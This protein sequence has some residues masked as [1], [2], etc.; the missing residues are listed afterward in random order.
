MGHKT[1]GI[2]LGTNSL[3]IA[4]R[5]TDLGKDILDQL[6]FYTSIIFKSGVGKS[7]KGEY[8]YAS[9][10]TLYRSRRRLYQSRKYRIWATLRLLIKHGCCPLTIEELEQ[11]SKYDKAKGQKRQYPIDATQFEQWV[12]LDF[13]NDGIPEYSSPYQLRAE[14]IERRLDWEDE[15]DR[16]KFGRAMYH[17]AQ[18]RGFKSSK[19]ETLKDAKDDEDSST[20]DVSNAMKKSEEKKSKGLKEYMDAHGLKTVGSAF[21]KLEQEGIRIRN[22]EYQAVQSQYLNEVKEICQYQH[23][24]QI[25]EELFNGLI[26]TKKGEGTIFYRRPLRSQKGNIGSCT[27]ERGRRRCPVSHPDYEEFRALSFINNIKFKLDENDTWQSLS[28]DKRAKLLNKVFIRANATFKFEDIT[29]WLSTEYPGH[30]FS[31]KKR[32]INYNDYTTV[33]GCPIIYRLTKILGDDWR[34]QIISTDKT[35]KVHVKSKK[36]HDIISEHS[37]SYNYEDIWHLCF[38]SDDYETLAEFAEVRMGFCA[39]KIGQIKRLWSIMQDGY[40]SLSLKAI[41][42]ILPLLREGMIYSEAVSLAKVSDIIGSEKWNLKRTDIIEGV[43]EESCKNEYVRTIYHIANTLISDYKSRTI[44]EKQGYRNTSY[45]LD[46]QDKERIRKCI[47]DT[48]SAKRWMQKSKE[49]QDSIYN[50]IETLFQDFFASTR[51]DYYVIP[52]QTERL[53]EYFVSIFPEI[54]EEKWDNLYHHSQISLFQKQQPSIM[55]DGDRLLHIFQ[56]GSPNIGSIKNPVAMRALHVVRRTINELLAKGMIDETTRIVVE[57][58]RD[59]NDANWRKAIERYQKEREKE[60][61]IITDI[62]KEFR[63]N[64][65]ESDIEKGR[66]LFEQIE[67]GNTKDEKAAKYAKATQAEKAK[68]EKFALDLEKYNLWKEQKF[69]CLYTGTYISIKNLFDENMVDIEHT[70]PRSI[71]FDDSLANK[72]ICNAHYNRTIKINRIPSEL[73]EYE[74]ILNRIKPWMEKVEHIKSQ[75]ENWKKNARTATTIERKNECIQQKHQWEMELNYW[76]AKV[77]SFKIQK[78]ELDQGFRNR[79]LVDTRIIT[80]YAFHYLKSVF[81]RVDVQKGS[82]TSTFRKILG[83]QSVDEKKDREKHS[84]H[85]IDAAVLTMIPTSVQRDRMIELFY[86]RQEADELEKD[87]IQQKLLK[88]IS[89]CRLGTINGMVSTIE[90]N[91]LINHIT[92]DQTL[93]PAKKL[94]RIGK[95]KIKGQWMQGDSIRGSLHQE[96][97]YGAIKDKEEGQRLVIRKPINRIGEKD[98][99]SI[100]DP[101]VRLSIET[102]VKKRMEEQKISFAKA[103]EQEMY[104]LDKDGQPITKGKNGKALL[105]IRHVRCYAKAGRGYLNV[106]TA[107]QIKQQTYPSKYEYKNTYYAQNEDNYLCLFYEGIAK[108][109]QSKAFKLINY[110]D[111]AQLHIR[112]IDTMLCE[113]EFAFYEGNENMPLKAVIKKG[114]RVLFYVNYPD[115]IN[116][117]DRNKL[118]ERLFVVYKF[119]II[120][121][122]T[123]YLRHHLEARKDKECDSSE[124]STAFSL[125]KKISYI[126]LKANSLKALI[127]HYDFEIDALGNIDFNKKDTHR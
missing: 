11:W 111:I 97:F 21:Y 84:H 116:D 101:W 7:D 36:P 127:E 87:A 90:Q 34:T 106:D 31:Y 39:E 102:Q 76:Q 83:V 120:G 125:S 13:N 26:S 63:P 104:L 6:E 78:D 114:T 10:R 56:L 79:Q 65:S 74:S 37:I 70:I 98:L 59:M 35:R 43:R 51:R 64:Y 66:L 94:R 48:I 61:D 42:N 57:T 96:Q 17:I 67:S 58:A 28:G 5:D 33:A 54:P 110:F 12:R 53:K 88:E 68:A 9:E 45:I 20:F 72:T 89:S 77:N 115:E 100:V 46:Q 82:V 95:V 60:N 122:P 41:R 18:R 23:L 22:S 85:A 44:D 73:D 119:N 2:D 30:E 55:E 126:S 32:T 99:G 69:R 49:E 25:N 112:N 71:S 92:K 105:P 3:G 40:A 27:L 38:S 62:I 123:L 47:I 124:T 108:G 107:L 24:D 117:L 121:T 50:D 81:E 29:K 8:S 19:G 52:R 75:I 14:M 113:P 91:I 109:K 1:V 15:T 4:V 118:S 86:Q 103:I 80:K 93:S 16:Y